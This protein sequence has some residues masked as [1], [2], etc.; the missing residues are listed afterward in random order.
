MFLDKNYVLAQCVSVA[1]EN[2][3]KTSCFLTS[4]GGLAARKNKRHKKSCVAQ[5]LRCKLN[6]DEMTTKMNPKITIFGKRV[7]STQTSKSSF[8]LSRKKWLDGV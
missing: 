8:V 5:H 1:F 2:D 6:Y 3:Q 7:I 4:F